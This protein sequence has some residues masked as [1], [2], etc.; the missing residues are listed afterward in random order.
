MSASPTRPLHQ[1]ERFGR[2]WWLPC[3]GQGNGLSDAAWA[4]IADVDGAVVP[5]LLAEL[6]ADAVP[7]YAAPISGRP[8][9]RSRRS[10]KIR[11]QRRY[12]LWV[13]TSAYGRAEETLRLALSAS[14][15]PGQS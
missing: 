13:G 10:P 1:P 11:T 6:R 12:S 5:S 9:P 14:L 8:G 4:P 7:A 3:N 2:L 15:R